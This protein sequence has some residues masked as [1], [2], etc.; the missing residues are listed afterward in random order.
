MRERIWRRRADPMVEQ[1]RRMRDALVVP[2]PWDLTV[3]L[4]Q[5][6]GMVG[7]RIRLVTLPDRSGLPCGLVVEQ[8]EDIVIAYDAESS[9]Y[10]ADHIV[11]H[12]IGH[13]LL[14]HGPDA[15]ARTQRGT[16]EL[17]FPDIDPDT[18]LRV[19]QRSDYDDAAERQAELFASLVMSESR[20]APAG[21]PFRRTMFP[22]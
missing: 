8:I 10:H 19:L 14:D 2:E 6:P 22:D 4:E 9:G 16:L 5:I 7:K 1:V 20:T 21:S 11:L 18:V 13:L 3:F 12:E 17:L 15:G